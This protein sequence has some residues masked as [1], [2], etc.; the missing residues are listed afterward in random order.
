MTS[1]DAPP[2]ARLQNLIQGFRPAHAI[3]VA[4]RLDI[5]SRLQ[6][7]PRSAEA[8][9]KDVSAD[10]RTLYRLLRAL[11]SV[12][13]FVEGDDQTFTLNDLGRLLLPNEPGSLYA[14]S[15]LNGAP[16][17]REA[18]AHLEDAVRTGENAFRLVFGTDD[19]TWRAEHPAENDIFNAAMTGLSRPQA[20]A[21]SG[22]FDFTR[23]QTVA[24]IGGGNGTLLA[25]VLGAAPAARGMLF[26]R[27][28]VVSGG[29]TILDR[30]GVAGR[31]ELVAGDFFESVPAGLDLYMVQRVLHD[32]TDEECG[33]IL[34]VIRKAMRADSRLLVIEMVVSGPNV[35]PLSKFSD[36]NMLVMPGGRERTEAEWRELLSGSGFKAVAFN[37]TTSPMW[38][39]EAEP[40]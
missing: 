21:A 25:A 6:D 24:D 35:D 40:V 38:V 10:P 18:W 26:D 33:K 39:I 27:A 11:A 3:Y 22:A 12:G 9:A 17:F 19:W 1:P 16:Y 15:L 2:A 7:G 36:L 28:H 13:V 8:L 29:G 30:S 5:A 32:W 34:T 4:A 23:F 20:A 31:Y 37:R 14:L